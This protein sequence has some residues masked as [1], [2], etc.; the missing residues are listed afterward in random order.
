M[1]QNLMQILHILD[2]AKRFQ[3]NMQ[4]NLVSTVLPG[5]VGL[6]GACFCNFGVMHA[7]GLNAAGAVVGATTTV[8]PW[9]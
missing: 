5:F 3:R 8:W 4:F 9:L 2:I 6:Y 1:N 7:V